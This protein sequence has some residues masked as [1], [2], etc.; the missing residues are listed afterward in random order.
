M[1]LLGASILF[2]SIYLAGVVVWKILK[3]KRARQIIRQRFNLEASKLFRAKNQN[4]Y[5][6]MSGWRRL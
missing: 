3:V 1:S 5:H 6:E 2:W 4:R